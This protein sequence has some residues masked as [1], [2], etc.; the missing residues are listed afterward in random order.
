MCSAKDAIVV[1]KPVCSRFFPA[2]SLIR[3]HL[4][5][6]PLLFLVAT[7]PCSNCIVLLPV[8]LQMLYHSLRRF[9][10]ERPNKEAESDAMLGGNGSDCCSFLANRLR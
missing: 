4:I 1:R 10:Y 9:S 3:A 8:N 6:A 5:D 7:K 2:T